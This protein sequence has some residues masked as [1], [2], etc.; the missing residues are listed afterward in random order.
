MF[1]GDSSYCCGLRPAGCQ[2]EQREQQNV[3][4]Q[5]KWFIWTSSRM[6]NVKGTGRSG[7]NSFFFIIVVFFFN[8]TSRGIFK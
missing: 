7:A 5:F 1:G 8:D 6:L 4:G 2:L 3:S